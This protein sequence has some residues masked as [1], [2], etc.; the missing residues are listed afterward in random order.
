M[1]GSAKRRPLPTRWDRATGAVSSGLTDQ[2]SGRLMVSLRR[3]AV[4]VARDPLLDGAHER[5]SE[6]RNLRGQLSHGL[7]GEVQHLEWCVGDDGCGAELVV[8]QRHL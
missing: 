1:S 8:D 3:S 6:V 5:I 2:P 4:L 7:G